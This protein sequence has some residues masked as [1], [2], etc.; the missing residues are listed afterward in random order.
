MEQH[1][2]ESWLNRMA[3]GIVPLF[4]ALDAPCPMPGS[5]PVTR[6]C[7]R[8]S[9]RRLLKCECE[10]CGYTVRT[11]CKWL[12][13]VGPPL[14]PVVDHGLMRH[15]PLNADDGSKPYDIN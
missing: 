1:N 13:T 2:R 6:Q 15:D 9:R 4:K 8:R 3:T 7:G 11:A 12:E 5:T 14:C 10:A